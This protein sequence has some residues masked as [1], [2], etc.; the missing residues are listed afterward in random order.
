[1]GLGGM[2]RP[3]AWAALFAIFTSTAFAGPSFAQAQPAHPSQKARSADEGLFGDNRTKGA[4]KGKLHVGG[5]LSLTTEFLTNDDLA[6]GPDNARARI[7][8]EARVELSY[9][10]VDDVEAFASLEV[11]FEQDRSDDRR[12]RSANVRVREAYL[13]IQDVIFND[14]ELQIGRQDFKDGREWL[15]KERLDGLRLAYDR[16]AW[17]VELAWAREALVPK[18]LLRSE[19]DR[20]KVD[21]FIFR[22]QY[23]MS[24]DWKVAAYVL[25]QKD[26]RAS[27]ISPIFFGV[28][29][30]GQLGGGFDHWLEYSIQ[31]GE[32][33]QRKL[34][35]SAFDVGIIYNF[36]M[37]GRPSIFGGYA[38]GSGG[39]D[40]KTTRTF[41]QTGLQD[42][43][44]RISGLGQ[45]KYY[46]E[47]LDPDLS[48]IA[49]FTAG[50]GVRPSRS[51]SLE[52]V[53][54]IFKQASLRRD[55]IRGS[56][57]TAELNGLRPNIGTEIDAIF[58]IR[59]MR[60]LGLEAKLGW[61]SPSSGF[62]TRARED[63]IF[64]K[65]RIVRRF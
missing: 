24:R 54:H 37:T 29:S 12:T 58:A 28:Q 41:R 49:I 8:P 33:G 50:A 19:P 56:P 21:N 17:R 2:T 32:A 52:I 1:M 48:N 31:R 62:D 59:L 11:G 7:R 22:A 18:G 61:F 60:G 38:R 5:R 30:E 46:G 16:R 42:N 10:P 47:L 34:R 44:D 57:I 6:R 43:E 55:D 53:G 36:P 65:L 63:A 23:E 25:R 13:L 9:E 3:S 27:N 26:R 64:G 14:F 40:A 45:V 51:S 35:A 15:Y 20:D 4:K 39:G